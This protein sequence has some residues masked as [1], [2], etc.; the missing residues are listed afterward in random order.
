[1]LQSYVDLVTSFENLNLPIIS[2][3]VKFQINDKKWIK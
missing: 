3:C 1:M 2:F